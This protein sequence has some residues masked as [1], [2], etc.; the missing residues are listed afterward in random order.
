MSNF[1]P[2][3]ELSRLFFL[4][5]VK[6]I[7][8]AEFP[9]L[10]YGASLIGPGSEVLGFDTEM[11]TDHCWGPRMQLFLNEGEIARA[12]EID[13]ALRKSLPYTFRSYPTHCSQ[14]DPN[15]N[16]TWHLEPLRQGEVNH[17]VQISALRKY[18]LDHLGFDTKG[19]IETTDWLTFP[20]QKLRTLKADQVFHDDIWVG[21]Q[22]N[23]F[24]W[25]PHDVW[26][27]LLSAGWNRVSQEEHLMGRA[28]MVGD[29]V[30]SA[31]IA[32]RLVRDLMRLCFLIEKQYAP[33]PKWFGTAFNKLE[34]SGNLRPV[35]TEVLAARSWRERENHLAKAYLLVAEMHDKS[36]I[37]EPIRAEIGDFFGR[38]FKVIHLHGKFAEAIAARIE[39]PAIRRL[40]E[41]VPIGNIDQV[42]DNTDLLSGPKYRTALKRLYVGNIDPI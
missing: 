23:R 35:F 40:A 3:L 18:L 39:D 4:E 21:E 17:A 31:I 42:S 11:S 37:T 9:S 28:G 38:P 34:C 8:D 33:Y 32:S 26:L 14:P 19:E 36:G 7:I 10:K 15:D 12:S 2:G 30:G 16:G 6:P 24:R 29:E 27:Y 1:I 22:L 25:Y 41:T 13:A 20:E 5:A